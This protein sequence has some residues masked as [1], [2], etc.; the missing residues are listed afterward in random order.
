MDKRIETIIEALHALQAKGRYTVFYDYSG[1]VNWISVRI[2]KGKWSK[3]KKPVF[4]RQFCLDH[5]DLY[6]ISDGSATTLDEFITT[7]SDLK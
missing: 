2:Y 7:I 5:P 4:S 6:N 1:H 3:K